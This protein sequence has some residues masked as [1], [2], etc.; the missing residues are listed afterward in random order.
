V[1]IYL[2][3]WWVELVKE[4]KES[5]DCGCK[6]SI[7]VERWNQAWQ[8][9]LL[10]LK[11]RAQDTPIARG[12]VRLERAFAWEAMREGEHSARR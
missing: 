7:Q 9:F 3:R 2:R 1:A 11:L 5:W 8:A 10:L 4:L 12:G 6:G